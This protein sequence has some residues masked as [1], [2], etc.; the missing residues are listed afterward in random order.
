MK[1]ILSNIWLKRFMSLFSGLY[2]F[3][4]CFLCYCS[5][6]YRVEISSQNSMCVL[7]SV[8][9][10]VFL[11]IMLYTRKQLITKISSFVVL[12][13]MLPVVLFYFGEWKL[14]IPFLVAGLI[15]FLF[16]GAGEGVK[17]TLGTIILLLYIFGSLGYF[18]ITSFFITASKTETVESG[19]SP[20]GKYRYS[21]VNTKDSSK[22]STAV[23]VEPND[24]DISLPKFYITFRINNFD[25][26]VYLE[27]PLTKNIK[28]EWTE[29]SRSEITEQLNKVS[30][31]IILHLTEEQLEILGYTYE[32][33]LVV[34]DLEFEDYQFLGIEQNTV[35][36]IPLNT[37]N[38]EQLAHFNIAKDNNG[39][40]VLSPSEEFAKDAHADEGEKIYLKDLKSRL[41][42]D[43]Y[44]EKDD[45]V[46]LNELTDEQLAE[47]GVPESGD[48]MTFNGQ[49][50]FRYYVAIL[51][52]YF[53]V[54][55]KRLELF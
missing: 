18:L 4:A 49:V 36:E 29:Q 11:V 32:E 33:K 54:E 27:R 24:A 50:C 10:A 12:P 39:Y 44:I 17:T 45:S 53:D 13:A 9:S 14:I 6:F 51:D 34:T 23:Y 16:S 26:I 43:L 47:L 55:H 15:I 19:I 28:V 42:E 22:G 8:L 41:L 31:H 46:I 52:N 1:N 21:V 30:D 37:L 40:Y 5:L 3:G 25:R 2:A 38:D 7:I 20:S 35:Q 48:V